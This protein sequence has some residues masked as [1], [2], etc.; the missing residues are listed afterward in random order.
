M[1]TFVLVGDPIDE[2]NVHVRWMFA[3]RSSPASKG[4]RFFAEQFTS[5]VTQDIPIWENKIYRPLPV[6]TKSESG[7]SPTGTGRSSSTAT[8]SSSDRT[9]DSIGS[10][11]V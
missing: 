2:D 7:S 6:L 9:T 3:C 11:R 8:T 10:D 5:G 4:A 1:L